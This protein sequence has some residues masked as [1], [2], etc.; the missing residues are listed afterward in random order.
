MNRLC[1]TTFG[2]VPTTVRR[3]SYQRS[4]LAPGIV[5]LGLG[6]FHRAHQA[7]YTDLSLEQAFGPWGVCGVSLR[8][9]DVRDRL[10]PQDGLYTVASRD[11]DGQGLQIVGCFKELLVAPEDPSAVIERIA[12]AETALVSLTVTEKGYCHDP[13]TGRLVGD[14]EDIRHDLAN[15]A[16][17]RSALGTLVAGLAHRRDLGVPPPT[18]LSCD[19]LPANGATLRGLAIEL[20][21]LQDEDLA[22]WIERK[23]AFPCSMVDRI[24]PATTAD[25]IASI[26]AM[27]GLHDAAPV[28]CEGFRQWVIEDRFAGPRPAWELAGAELVP[29]VAPYEE[30]KLR[31]LNGSHSAIAYLGYLAGLTYVSE[32]MKAPEFVAF[33]RGMMAEVAPTLEVPTDLD[34]YQSTLLQRFANPA[35]AHRTAQIAMDGSQKLPQRLL[36]PIRDRLRLGGTIGH[37]CLAVAAWIRYASGRD[38]QGRNIEVSDPLASA[39]AAIAEQAGNDPAAL[40]RGFFGLTE[41]F[42]SDLPDDERFTTLVTDHLSSLCSKGARATVSTLAP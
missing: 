40:A 16:R 4:S 19:N 25:D 17:P 31:L 35:L 33:L 6:A 30:M 22:R 18:I 42:G 38:E 2:E 37:L 1:K 39:M 5:H 36:A 11:G 13:A 29:D 26:D 24:V 32:V 21:A 23:V 8:H 9:P 15:P 27:L 28:V 20:A 10:A 34:T 14:H 12:A 7:I 3:W 41:V